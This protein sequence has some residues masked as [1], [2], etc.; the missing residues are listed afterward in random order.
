MQREDRWKCSPDVDGRDYDVSSM[1]LL[2]ETN[3]KNVV[4]RY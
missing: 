2:A 1:I 4:C 3:I